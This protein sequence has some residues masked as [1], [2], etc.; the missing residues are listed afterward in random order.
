VPNALIES[1]V[2]EMQLEAMR[3]AG[4][5]DRSQA[6]AAQPFIEPARRRAALGLI[7]ADIIKRENL[8]ADPVRAN[9]RL[10]ELTSSYGDPAAMR[11]AY[12]QNPEAMRQVEN[13]ALEDQVVDWVLAHA[14]V[15]EVSST[16]KEL[17]KF[18]A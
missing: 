3:R 17:M 13:L 18:E 11:Q 14:K 16:F 4:Q 10:D 6:P 7:L 1:Q 2:R 9:A 8:R 15:R 12:L 5:K